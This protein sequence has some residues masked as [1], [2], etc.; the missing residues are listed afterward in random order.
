MAPGTSISRHAIH[1]LLLKLLTVIS[2]PS[3]LTA[4]YGKPQFPET[5]TPIL[6]IHTHLVLSL[7]TFT[8]FHTFSLVLS[9]T[10]I[11]LP[12][13]AI[14]LFY[15]FEAK[16][17]YAPKSKRNSSFLYLFRKYF[18]I[19]I[20]CSAPAFP[21]AFVR[22]ITRSLTHR[23]NTPASLPVSLTLATQITYASPS[24]AL[25]SAFP[26]PFSKRVGPPVPGGSIQL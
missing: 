25:A 22:H 5:L 17:V 19:F 4:N 15:A 8:N 6:V 1:F 12:L 14:S 24:C 2:R 16:S 23:C 21:F 18:R 11:V 7:F 3:L 10:S 26:S 9:A 13:S 20:M